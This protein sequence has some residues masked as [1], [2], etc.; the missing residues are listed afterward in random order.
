MNRDTVPSVLLMMFLSLARSPQ[1]PVSLFYSRDNDMPKILSGNQLHSWA[2]ARL[3]TAKPLLFPLHQG[4]SRPALSH[5]KGEKL[6]GV[7]FWS[8]PLLSPDQNAKHSGSV[9]C[10]RD[11]IILYPWCCG[12]SIVSEEK[13]ERV[14]T[15]F[16]RSLEGTHLLH[17]SI[18]LHGQEIK[19]TKLQ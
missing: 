3:P 13:L 8:R 12:W 2:S 16:Q 7:C 4:G 19:K 17:T 18:N 5:S 11:P 1:E 9:F 6:W 15:V 14:Y 10:H